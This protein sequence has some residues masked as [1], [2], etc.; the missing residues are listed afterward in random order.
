M[1]AGGVVFTCAACAPDVPEDAGPPPSIVVAFDPSIMPPVAPTPNDLTPRD[2]VSG[3]LQIPSA[4][5]DTPTQTE[6]NADYLG[7][8]TAFPF[9]ST[10]Q[11]LVTGALDPSTVSGQ[12]VVVIDVTEL[13]ALP[14]SSG[15]ATAIV[16]NLKPTFDPAANALV[17]GPPSGG[18][19]RAHQYAVV[20]VTPSI[21]HPAGLRGASGERVIG[22]PAW[23]L[24]SSPSPLVVCPNG[25]LTSP[26]CVLAVDVI[27]SAETD[28]TQ[29]LADQT[30][31]AILLEQVRLGLQPL[32]EK[33]ER[34]LGL[35][36][37]SSIPMAW[38]FTIIDAGEM[39]FD[40]SNGI[41]P[42]PNDLLRP[43]GMVSLPSPITGQPLSPLDCASP[44]DPSTA[45]TCGLNTLDGFSTIAAPVSENGL[46]TGAAQQAQLSAAS[47]TP[48]GLGLL[49]LASTAPVSTTPLY[50]PCLNCLSSPTAS[51]A[52]QTSPQ[53]LQWQLIA[54]LDEDT[55]YVA[56]VTTAV[57]DDQGK[58]VAANPLF[59][60]LRLTHPLYLDG[61]SQ[62]NVLT[63]SQ[64]AALEPERALLSP[65]FDTLDKMN[66]I[67]R[68]DV[69][70]AWTFT[71]QSESTS[72]DAL[73]AYVST[74]AF[75]AAL[76]LLPPGIV[77][78][79]DWTAQY[80]AAAAASVPSIP[81]ANIGKFYIGIYETPLALTGQGGTLDLVHPVAE[82]VTFGL[83]VP[84]GTMPAAGYPVTVFG[85]GITRDHN[86]FLAIA[87]ELAAQGQATLA[88]DAPLHGERSSCTGYGAYAT[89]AYA[90]AHPSAPI[91]LTDDSACADP[92]TM[93][94]DEDSLI[95]RC[96]ARDPSK[97][98]ACPMPTQFA[99]A[100][101]ALGCASVHM[102]ACEADGKCEGG[103]FARDAGGRPLISGWNM[104][105]LTNFF[106][107]RD[108]LREQV[109]DLAQLVQALRATVPTSLANRISSA[110]GMGAAT[111][112]LT[113]IN[114]VGQSLGGILGTL[115]NA[116]SPD[117]TH[118]VLNVAG[119]DLPAL[120]LDAPSFAAQRAPLLDELSQQTPPVVPGTPA[121]DQFLATAQ[122]VLDPADPAN[123]V[124]RLTHPVAASGTM[125]SASANRETFI[126]FIEG[127]ET[128][129][130]VSNL[131]LVAAAVRPGSSAMVSAFVPPS[132]GCS[133]PLSCYEFT[134]TLDGYTSASAPLADRDGF[135]LVPPSAQSAALT[136]TAQ[137]QVATFVSG[138]TLQ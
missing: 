126:Q 8:L 49:S 2:P 120:F 11:A 37:A 41:I 64:A 124:W 91:S 132:Y 28:P 1:M 101:G 92:A 31:K 127:D 116:V 69:A 95:G 34:L 107:T 6:F 51:G 40:P 108:N 78:F 125:A 60:L 12:S 38:S 22:S 122:W 62:V 103:D 9:E 109:V 58:N 76:P 138:G 73:Y 32:L 133:L 36:D 42:F 5:T 94:C 112:D 7:S 93:M 134:E 61:K 44:S 21:A 19:T 136:V 18:W 68:Q 88:T 77:V 75:K 87:N 15:P 43:N 66:G 104:F 16:G 79:A 89:T 72:L 63:D 53:Q 100:T 17:V 106:T 55:T 14:A 45:L 105:S 81:I 56:Y 137:N 10:A 86:D 50:A 135:L 46:S 54:P 128:V 20:L 3:K 80:T 25:D 48:T 33:A 84:N 52:Q 13:D 113:K 23:A 47:L 65:A 130:N 129:P 131:A 27:P 59:A 99:D 39:T 114:Y 98:I 96:V 67:A 26:Q 123:M 115:F 24:V 71:T 4:V 117:T 29:R 111:L 74:Q 30:A 57:L 110:G 83:A 85:H 35:S 97:R 119:G 90:S 121:F 118:V 70:L 102:G 82:P